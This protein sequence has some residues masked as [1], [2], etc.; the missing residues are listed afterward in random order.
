MVFGVIGAILDTVPTE[1][2]YTPAEINDMLQDR[3]KYI[4]FLW[5]LGIA[6]TEIAKDVGL[7]KQRVNA[8]IHGEDK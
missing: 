8:I 2:F 7:T 6:Q 3:D 1:R 4:R 5:R